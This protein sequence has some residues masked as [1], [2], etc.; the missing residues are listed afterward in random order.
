MTRL[1]FIYIVAPLT[2]ALN[3][4]P[5]F[6]E[7]GWRVAAAVLLAVAVWAV[8]WIRVYSTGKLRPEFAILAVIPVV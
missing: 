2:V 1:K 7:G 5:G 4:L 3:A 8:V 6:L